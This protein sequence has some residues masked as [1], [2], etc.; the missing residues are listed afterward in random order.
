L[1]HVPASDKRIAELDLLAQEKYENSIAREIR[2]SN[3]LRR[4]AEGVLGQQISSELEETAD[5]LSAA[6]EREGGKSTF[7]P[8][9]VRR[10]Y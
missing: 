5:E 3:A 2:E 9:N 7:S 1:G 4:K 8:M 6:F 10:S